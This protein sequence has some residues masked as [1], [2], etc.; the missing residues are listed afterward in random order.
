MIKSLLKYPRG[1]FLLPSTSD[2]EYLLLHLALSHGL[3]TSDEVVLTLQFSSF[4]LKLAYLENLL[5]SLLSYQL[6][7]LLGNTSCLLSK[8]HRALHSL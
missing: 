3:D 6:P 4:V 8:A 1:Y 7:C 5:I 2:S